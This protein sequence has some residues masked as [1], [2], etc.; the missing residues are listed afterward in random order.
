MMS[1]WRMTYTPAHTRCRAHCGTALHHCTGQ[2]KGLQ[3]PQLVIQSHPER[4]Q[5]TRVMPFCQVRHLLGQSRSSRESY[6]VPDAFPD[7]WS[8]ILE[9]ESMESSPACRLSSQGPNMQSF[10]GSACM[11]LVNYQLS[12]SCMLQVTK[13]NPTSPTTLY[14]PKQ[15]AQLSC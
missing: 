4:G 6:Q 8:H 2:D 10:L 1:S 3:A 12:P 7:C 11:A 13:G 9:W 5:G 14:H 15:Y